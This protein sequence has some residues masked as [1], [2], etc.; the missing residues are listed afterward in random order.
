MKTKKMILTLF[1]C[2]A[3]FFVTDGIAQDGTG[4]DMVEITYMRAKQGQDSD[5]IAAVNAHNAA[6]HNDGPY[7]GHIDLIQTG[8]ESGWYVYIM[9]PCTFTDLDSRP[10][11]DAHQSDWDDNVAP[12]VARMG[13][14]EYWQFNPN[15]SN[16][17]MANEDIKYET[18]WFIDVNQDNPD[19]NKNISEFLKMAKTVNE[20]L[21]NDYREY[22]SRFG[23]TDGR[24]IALVFPHKSLADL[25]DNMNFGKEFEEVHGEGSF[26]KALKLWTSAIKSIDRQLWKIGIE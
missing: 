24:D 9:G 13:R 10:S 8:R 16:P 17:V 22:Y 19:A 21:G 18:V 4:Y 7:A 26:E 14:T 12:H 23:G 25:D 2:A 11:T 3:M 1:F 20:K 15:L 5:F 6:Y